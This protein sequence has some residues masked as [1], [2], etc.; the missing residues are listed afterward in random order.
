MSCVDAKDFACRESAIV[1]DYYLA[2]WFYCENGQRFFNLPAFYLK[3]GCAFFINGRHRTVVLARYLELL[4]MALT[5]ID[6]ESEGLLER[7]VERPLADGD[8]IVLPD[9]PIIDRSGTDRGVYDT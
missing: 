6:N 5:Q 3:K 2:D 9:L 8:P 4:P 7:L 1:Q